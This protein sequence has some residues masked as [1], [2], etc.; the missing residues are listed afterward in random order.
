MII[1]TDYSIDNNMDRKYTV[2]KT[3]TLYE[4]ILKRYRNF[5]DW[6]HF[7]EMYL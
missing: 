6:F 1:H 2:T 3:K 7:S 5:K 4:I